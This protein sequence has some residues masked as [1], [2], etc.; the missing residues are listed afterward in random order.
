MPVPT[1]QQTC[2]YPSTESP[3]ISTNF[4]EARPI[5]VGSIA[6]DGDTITLWISLGQFSDAVD[7]YLL[8]FAPAIDPVSMYVINPDGTLQPISAGLQP[9]R[10]NTFGP[11]DEGLFGDIQRS[12]L[13]S[14][15]YDLYLAVTP[16]RSMETHYLW[17]T[18][19]ENPFE[20]VP[21]WRT[22]DPAV[23]SLTVEPE[24]AD[25]GESVTM[26]ASV[27]NLGRG[28]AGPSAL[29]FFLDGVEVAR[30][31][32][33][34][35]EPAAET[36]V[37]AVWTAEGPGRHQVMA[38]LELGENGADRSFDNNF[39]TSTARVSGE[40]FPE[41]EL[42]FD[43][44]D[45]DSLQLIPGQSQTITLNIRNPSFAEISN[46]PLHVYVDGERVSS[47]AIEY[48]TP[49]EGQELQFQWERITPGE[50]MI[51]VRMELPDGFPNAPAQ[52]V[53]SWHVLV[54]DA[55]VLYEISQ[56]DK[57][58]SIGPRTLTHGLGGLPT[59]S[60]GR[61]DFIAFHPSNPSIM[62][63]SAPTGGLWKTT[64]AGNSWT[65]LTDKLPSLRAAAVA[66][67]PQ[68]PQ[69]VCFATGSSLYKGGIGFYKSIDGG[70]NWH[71]FATKQVAEGACKLEIR[72]PTTGQVMIYAGTNRGVLR[73]TSSNPTATSSTPS[74]W[75]QIKTGPIV[76][77]AVSPTDNSLVYASVLKDGLYRTRSGATAT[78]NSNW[79]KLTNG[80]P[81]ITLGSQRLVFDIFQDDP[82]TLHA[83]ISNPFPF[84]LILSA[85][86][87]GIYTSIDEGD[88]WSLVF[89]T[90]LGGLY[91]PFIRTHPH[92]TNLVYFGGVKLYKKALGWN[93]SPVLITGIHDDMKTMEYDPTNP[94][95]Y[96]ILND[97]GI[98][99]CT[100]GA[101]DNCT[102]KN[103]DL[104]TTM[105][106]DFDASRTNSNLMIGGTQD[107]GTILYQGNPDWKI[108]KGGDGLFS[109]IAPTNNQVMYAQHQFLRDTARSDQGVNSWFNTWQSRSNGLPQ[110]NEWG[111]GNAYIT[112]HPNSAD[113]LL[114]QGKEVYA[115][116]NGGV[117]WTPRGPKGSNVKGNVTRVVIQPNTFTWIAGTIKGQIWYTSTG[118]SPWYLL[119]DH[120][121]EVP[122]TSLAFAPTDYKV[123]YVTFNGGSAYMRIWRLVMNPGPP[124]T[125]S[126]YNITD[127]FPT[128]RHPVVI[129]GDGHSADKAYIGT[130]SGVFRGVDTGGTW[131]WQPYSKGLPL[132][133]IRDLLVDPSSKELR[134]ATYGRGAWSVITGP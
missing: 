10:D 53:K 121:D 59:G 80:L 22:P 98:F 81:N 34:A 87:L 11:I 18:G 55:T 122:V 132:A 63:A 103:Y 4:D 17:I 110:G 8:M 129:A 127:N 62:Y 21:A 32:V 109:L 25:P 108:I 107:N 114:S 68:N 75:V 134:A 78:G 118:G 89:T 41:P 88:S 82:A 113:Y 20:E 116:T 38:Q 77:M 85:I 112:V 96:Y 42:D 111:W 29:I 106:Y 52:S 67:D 46:I 104:R 86:T 1:G 33:E 43:R 15:T 72:Y 115:T 48:L 36:E 74:E 69:I 14:G 105:F 60:V 44:I 95:A 30:A 51:E 101:I 97:G 2:T 45:F 119:F 124:E 66:V 92:V 133:D 131:N 117:K 126:P 47:G 99:R 6:A 49:G 54:P 79:T 39:L 7:I 100:Q 76:D 5:G 128:N 12:T 120:P 50:H 3:I 102:P 123:L 65:P 83:A 40:E 35:L 37:N 31:D 91:N 57:W 70:A 71:H 13:P 24:R 61:M 19:F 125:W 58:A 84:D 56:Q 130:E 94:S 23:M 9:W 28:N 93:D 27:S 64:N 16:A 73:Y 26:R 90:L